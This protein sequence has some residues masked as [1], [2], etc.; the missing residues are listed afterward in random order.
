MQTSKV[1]QIMNINATDK[2]RAAFRK[3]KGSDWMR[4]AEALDYIDERRLR[5]ETPKKCNGWWDLGPAK[6]CWQSDAA[7]LGR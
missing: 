5:N 2:M 4:I 1:D 3:A 7:Q 6:T